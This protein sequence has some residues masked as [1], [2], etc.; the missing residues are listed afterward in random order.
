MAVSAREVQVELSSWEMRF[1]RENAFSTDCVA[2]GS[3]AVEV[4]W[5]WKW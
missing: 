1:G 2:A 3:C 4:M 5:M